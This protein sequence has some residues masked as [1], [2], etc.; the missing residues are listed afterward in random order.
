MAGRGRTVAF[1][2]TVPAPIGDELMLAAL[3]DSGGT[4]V[5]VDDEE[6]LADLRSSGQR[7]G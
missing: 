1:G 2:I 5:A 4:A 6:M 3:R 7:R